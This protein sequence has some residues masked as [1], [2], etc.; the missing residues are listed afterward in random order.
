MRP[1][2]KSFGRA[3][4]S[5][6]FGDFVIYRNLE[7]LDRRI[8]GLKT[9]YYRMGLPDEHIPRKLDS[10]YAKAAVWLAKQ[11]QR[12]RGEGVELSELVFVGD[13]LHNDG[14]AY[15]NM[16]EVSEWAGSCA[17]GRACPNEDLVVD[18]DEDDA[19]Y[20]VN[21]WSR[22]GRMGTVDAGTGTAP[23][24]PHRRRQST[25]TRPRSAQKVAT[26]V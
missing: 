15:A 25:S 4:L 18:I 16:I 22:L 7:P 21:R 8:P 14:Q 1:E 26:I 11:G 6:Y 3:A 13:T 12:L 19:V 23:G 17:I 9:A 2:M 24:Q 5:D 10:D 20:C